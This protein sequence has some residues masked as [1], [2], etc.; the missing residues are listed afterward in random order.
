[1]FVTA[2]IIAKFREYDEREAQERAAVDRY[3]AQLEKEE[4]FASRDALL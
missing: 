1:M 4:F 3:I 2:P